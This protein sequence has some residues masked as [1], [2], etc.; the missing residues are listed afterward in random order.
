MITRARAL[1]SSS[2]LS[3]V[4]LHNLREEWAQHGISEP[5][6]SSETRRSTSQSPGC[7]CIR[8]V[9]PYSRTWQQSRLQGA[10]L[11]AEASLKSNGVHVSL[12]VC[13]ALGGRHLVDELRSFALAESKHTH[14]FSF[15]GR[16]G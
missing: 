3:D 13:W 2:N 11:A 5:V 14:M 12:G 16:L 7:R 8:L 4:V 10:L 9:L 1:C 15:G 6:F